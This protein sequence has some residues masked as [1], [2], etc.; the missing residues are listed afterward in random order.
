MKQLFYSHL[1]T[2][3]DLSLELDTLEISEDERKHLLQIAT[4]SIHYELLN[5]ALSELPKQHKR[6]FLKHIHNED[7]EKAWHFLNDKTE[8]IE[9][10]LKQKAD[11]LKEEF[12]KD[13]EDLRISS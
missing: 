9:K 13:I 12:K 1:I 5:T 7:H 3:D 8:N 11:K 2:L 6:E 10:K 4:S